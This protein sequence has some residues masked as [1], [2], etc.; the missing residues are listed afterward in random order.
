MF[1]HIFVDEFQDCTLADY[2]LFYGLAKDNN[3]VVL[4]GDY[5]QAVHLGASSNAPRAIDLFQTGK[6]IMKRRTVHHLKG[7]YRLP[8]RITECLRPLSEHI[9]NS[10][11]DVDVNIINPYRG[12]PPGARPILV[13]ASSED[14]MMKKLAWIHNHYQIF[15]FEGFGTDGR[16]QITILEND[17]SLC[18]KINDT[19][20]QDLATTDTILRLKGMEKD[21]IVWSTR[22]GVN[23]PGDEDYFVYTILTR[24]RSVLIIALFDETI[25]RYREIV[26]L[27]PKDRLMLWD[28]ETAEYYN[29]NIAGLDTIVDGD[30]HG[31]GVE[32]IA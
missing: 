18:K 32:V 6:P 17:Y 25:D 7:S 1:T 29:S 5:A 12:A 21:C 28:G 22:I 10:R 26:K 15:N 8:F 11:S 16:R 3:E 31:A 24:T 4:T 19:Y 13:Y 23:T 14:E 20:K 2:Q 9:N 30:D 27:F